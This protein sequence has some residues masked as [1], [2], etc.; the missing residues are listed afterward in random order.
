MLAGEPT[1]LPCAGCG[2]KCCGPVP[3]GAG[4]WAAL[5][6]A[7]RRLPSQAVDRLEAQERPDLACPLRDVEADRC[8]VYPVRPLVCRLWGEDPAAPCP[9][10]PLAWRKPRPGEVARIKERLARE[11]GPVVGVLGIDLGW[12]EL[13]TSASPPRCAV[14]AGAGKRGK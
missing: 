2:G 13:R 6:E 8:A 5:V 9:Y 11:C 7:M 4:E 10:G 3:V 14:G 1:R 12:P